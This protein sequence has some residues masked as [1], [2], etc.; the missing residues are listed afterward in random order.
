LAISL[1]PVRIA[2]RLLV[3]FARLTCSAKVMRFG[4]LAF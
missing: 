1:V 3:W 4:L 2:T